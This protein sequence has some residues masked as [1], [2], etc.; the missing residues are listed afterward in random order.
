MS[1]FESS[2]LTTSSSPVV[3]RVVPVVKVHQESF[4]HHV[5]DRCYT[6][7]GGIHPVHRFQL[8]SDLKTAFHVNLNRMQT[9]SWWDDESA[10]RGQSKASA[11]SCGFVVERQL[12]FLDWQR[13]LWEP[14]VLLSFLGSWS[15]W[16]LPLYS[17]KKGHK[18]TRKRW[19]LWKTCQQLSVTGLVTEWTM[20]WWIYITPHWWDALCLFLAEKRMS[21]CH[22]LYIIFRLFFCHI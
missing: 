2:K 4:V 12:P 16:I 15:K 8:R 6:D 11:V 14:L 10:W 22:I 7:Q 13:L 18:K 1:P 21:I 5:S 17:L 19:T 9:H 3:I 20:L